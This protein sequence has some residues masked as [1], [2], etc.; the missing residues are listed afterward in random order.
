[1]PLTKR[2][3]AFETF[4]FA[5]SSIFIYD[6]ITSG[7][8]SWTWAT[9]SVYGLVG[10]AAAIFFQTRSFS[11]ANFVA[12]GVCAT[13]VYDI[14][15]GLTIGPLFFG[16]SFSIALAGQIPFTALHLAGTVLFSLTVSPILSA[17]LASPYL[18]SAA[19]KQA[20]HRAG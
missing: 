9:A 18:F 19:E 10:V 12:F 6:A 16:Q 7:I 11:R 17:W 13:L 15:T 8:G 20:I 4:A 14:L 5:F 1:M 2:F 3:G